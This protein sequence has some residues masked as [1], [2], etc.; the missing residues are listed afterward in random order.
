MASVNEKAFEYYPHLRKIRDHFGKYY[1]DPFSLSD[2]AALVGLEAKH[3]SKVFR[4]TVGVGFREWRNI[5]RIEK[6]IGMIS[7]EYQPLCDVAFAVG[8]QDLST[9]ERAFKKYTNMT[10]CEFRHRVMN[11]IK[12][13]IA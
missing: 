4:S 9:F 6:A 12:S 7:A 5:V 13:K 1:T 8:F 3:L 2:A 10:P 11:T